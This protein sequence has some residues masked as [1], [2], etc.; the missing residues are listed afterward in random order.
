MLF[1]NY[2]SGACEQIGEVKKNIQ[3]VDSKPDGKRPLRIPRRRWEHII[4]HVK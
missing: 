3:N 1:T 4:I 2:F